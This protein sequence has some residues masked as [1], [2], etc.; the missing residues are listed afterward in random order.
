M[1]SAS[2]VYL[3]TEAERLGAVVAFS[4]AAPSVIP[5]GTR[6]DVSSTTQLRSKSVTAVSAFRSYLPLGAE[7]RVRIITFFTAALRKNSSLP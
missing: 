1:A 7:V 6:L 3:A 2:R 5:T 4:R